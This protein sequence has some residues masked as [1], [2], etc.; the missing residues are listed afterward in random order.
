MC[1]A[2]PLL[3]VSKYSKIVYFLSHNK[4]HNFI[5]NVKKKNIIYALS[6]NLKFTQ[7]LSFLPSIKFSI[8]QKIKAFIKLK[9]EVHVTRE[10]NLTTI[11]TQVNAVFQYKRRSCR[12]YK[13]QVLRKEKEKRQKPT[14]HKFQFQFQ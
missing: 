7:F 14:K 12:D 13:V 8:H 10:R 3:F 4:S 2:V 5:I 1:K 9:N 6:K 11:A